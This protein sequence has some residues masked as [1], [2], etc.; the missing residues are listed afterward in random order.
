MA[1]SAGEP[2]G[3]IMAVIEAMIVLFMYRMVARRV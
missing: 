1:R 3:F 2:A